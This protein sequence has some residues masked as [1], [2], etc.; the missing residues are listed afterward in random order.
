MN[1]GILGVVILLAA[2]PAVGQTSFYKCKDQWGQPVFSQRPCGDNAVKGAVSGPQTLGAQAG[3]GEPSEQPSAQPSAPGASGDTWDRI[4]ADREIRSAER[5][6]NR[7]ENRIDALHRE[8]DR[9]VAALTRRSGY[10]NNNLAGAQL[11]ESL[12]TEMRAINEQY[13]DK[14]EREE[15]RLDRLREQIDRVRDAA[16]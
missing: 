15:R 13:R 10:A 2:V 9:K 16:Q 1:K 8:R 4:A 6:I 7:A 11:K 12:A 3:G 14:I 5:E